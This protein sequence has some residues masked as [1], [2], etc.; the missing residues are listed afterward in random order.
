MQIDI[1]FLGSSEGVIRLLSSHGN[2]LHFFPTSLQCS[3]LFTYFP[4]PNYSNPQKLDLSV[5]MM[6]EKVLQ[7]LLLHRITQTLHLLLLGKKEE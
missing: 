7:K 6:N 1:L 3:N 5:G 4:K 2:K